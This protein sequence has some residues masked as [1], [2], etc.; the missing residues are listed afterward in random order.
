MHIHISP[1][2]KACYIPPLGYTI[3]CMRKEKPPA[4]LSS[5]ELQSIILEAHRLAGLISS[6]KTEMQRLQA[7]ADPNNTSSS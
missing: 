2:V 3:H 5:E 4:K 6:A 7:E 1:Y